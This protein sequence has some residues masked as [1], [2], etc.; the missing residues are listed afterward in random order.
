MGRAAG[1]LL[2]TYIHDLFTRR[3]KRD[4]TPIEVP[5]EHRDALHGGERALLYMLV[6]DFLSNFGMNG[7]ACLL[8]AICEIHAHP[9]H[10]FGLI[11]EM[12][13]LF[14]T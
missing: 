8:R 12:F 3:K 13:K 11:G 6:E 5:P 14:L 10:N 2:G 1:N 7:K 9:L 4:I